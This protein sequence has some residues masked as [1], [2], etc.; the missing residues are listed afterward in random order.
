MLAEGIRDCL[1]LV[2]DVAAVETNI[3]RF[4]ITSLPASEFAERLSAKG[5]RVLP[6]GLD[7]IRAIP[8][9]NITTP[10]IQEAIE[11]IRSVTAAA[12][13]AQA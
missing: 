4:K 3:L 2:V 6:G 8:Y 13:A 10:Q 7:G 5:L 12:H 11:I 1:G 9:L